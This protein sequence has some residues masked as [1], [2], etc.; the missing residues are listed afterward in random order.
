MNSNIECSS[1]GLLLNK[2]GIYSSLQEDPYNT[3]YFCNFTC[4]IRGLLYRIKEEVTYGESEEYNKLGNYLIY[5]LDGLLSLNNFEL[6]KEELD[7]L[8]RR[9]LV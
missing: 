5:L 2:K 6:S 1:C 8:K 7:E 3:K 9:I 4:M